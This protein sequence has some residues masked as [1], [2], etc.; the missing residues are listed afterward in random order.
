[1]SNKQ[2]KSL[3]NAFLNQL[4][5]TPTHT[6]VLKGSHNLS[7]LQLFYH[8]SEIAKTLSEHG[9]EAGDRVVLLSSRDISG[10]IAVIGILMCGGVYVPIS[11]DYP[12]SRI[13]HI[14][15]D[16]E[17][18][19]AIVDKKLYSNVSE[20]C[21]YLSLNDLVDYRKAELVPKSLDKQLFYPT[22]SSQAAYILYT[23][24][25]TGRPK[26][27]VVSHAAV[28]NTLQWMVS[29][30][31]IKEG[32][33][34]PQKTPWG[35]TDSIWEMFLPL[36]TGAS[37][38]FVGENE[39]RDPISLYQ[40][41]KKSRCVITQFVPPALSS[42]LDGIKSEIDSPDLPDL[43]WV[44]N[45]GEELPRSLID[46]WFNIFPNIGYANSYG[47]TESAIYATCYFMKKPPPWGMRR[48]PIG[49][50][51]SNAQVFVLDDSKNVLDKD[52]IGEICIGGK[53]LMD[54]YWGQPE[55]TSEVL[56]PGPNDGPMVYR[57]GDYG[58]FRYDG[59]LAYL[60][61]RD[62]QI[63]IRGMRI[64]L[65]EIE[66]TLR[67]HSGIKQAAAIVKGEGDTKHLIA[68]Y[69]VIDHDPG[70]ENVVTFLSSKLPSHMVPV[71]C[72]FLEVMPITIHGKI[73][74]SAL[75]QTLI[76]N[77]LVKPAE[78]ALPNS[79]EESIWQVWKNVLGKD[80][81]GVNDGFFSVGGNSLL[82][83]QVYAKIPENYRRLISIIDMLHY[84]TISSLSEAIRSK[85]SNEEANEIN[86]NVM[87]R[88]NP[89]KLR[90]LRREN[91]NESIERTDD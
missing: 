33:T 4:E 2:H 26:G 89:S 66:N 80:D 39:V 11:P 40:M 1:M 23:S 36:M 37:V 76:L 35:F 85:L 59:E 14:I 88:R 50:P 86:G 34:I 5:L 78:K 69:S 7:Y 28:L 52:L 62:H 45:G 61:R 84:S 12:Q 72:I 75:Q 9:V 27:V 43:R 68:F 81:F 47:M 29:T 19:L 44:L 20:D 65:G 70:E 63:K 79:I 15:A 16:C 13:A 46:K 57:T 18:R 30:F 31:D 22:N 8:A 51:I 49:K 10:L 6:A 58:Y 55:L 54:G 91:S 71:R 25:T 38:S 17:C 82:L 48:I 67:Q 21:K 41:L 24:G 87:I 56:I 32:E 53:S 74:R 77:R 90:V 83:V 73:D 42:F 60:G 64:E 3:I